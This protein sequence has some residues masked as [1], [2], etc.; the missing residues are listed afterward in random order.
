MRELECM[1]EGTLGWW[2]RQRRR[3][4]AGT[5]RRKIVALRVVQD[6]AW[7]RYGKDG[8]ETMVDRILLKLDDSFLDKSLSTLSLSG[9][10]WIFVR[11]WSF[12]PPLGERKCESKAHIDKRV[13]KTQT[14][15]F[16]SFLHDLNEVNEPSFSKFLEC[17]LF[18][19]VFWGYRLGQYFICAYFWMR[20][21]WCAENC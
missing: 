11:I 8:C 14:G 21:K 5:E 16:F 7:M 13:F 17:S 1:G 9:I 10:H 6:A 15:F 18:P 19:M 2:R 4:C 12:F 20:M 3:A